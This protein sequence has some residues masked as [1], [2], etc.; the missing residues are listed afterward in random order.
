VLIGVDVSVGITTD[1][2][3][4]PGVGVDVG[5]LVD[6]SAGVPEG[7]PES[8]V[9]VCVLVGIV[10]PGGVNEGMRVAQGGT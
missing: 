6:I 7:R 1:V 10:T 8:G 3:D 2:S 9:K 5:T 4:A